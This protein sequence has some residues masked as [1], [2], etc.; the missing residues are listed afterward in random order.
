MLA[1]PGAVASN[2]AADVPL[3]GKPERYCVLLL[4]T[5]HCRGALCC[6]SLVGPVEWAAAGHVVRGAAGI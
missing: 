6:A 5:P 1:W 2:P 4:H 3:V